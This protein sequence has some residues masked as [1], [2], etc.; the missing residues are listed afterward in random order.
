MSTSSPT[1][2][3]DLFNSFETDETAVAWVLGVLELGENTT[4]E[5]LLAETVA[6][7]EGI[8]QELVTR[9]K[10]VSE[11]DKILRSKFMMESNNL[12]EICGLFE[13]H[14]ESFH[15]SGDELGRV[16]ERLAV[17]DNERSR[18][19]LAAEL[20][21]L[22]QQL[23]SGNYK[24]N[25]E[26]SSIEKE[27]RNQL[28]E[29]LKTLPWDTICDRLQELRVILADASSTS[30]QQARINISKVSEDIE[31]KMLVKFE[32]AAS[33]LEQSSSQF[34]T[35]FWENKQLRTLLADARLYVKCLHSFNNGFAVQKKF[36]YSCL[37]RM[38]QLIASETHDMNLV[39]HISK[40]IHIIG[41]VGREQF[42]IIRQ[43]FPQESTGRVC[44]LLLQKVFN[45]SSI[46]LV[47]KINNTLTPSTIVDALSLPESLDMLVVIREK[48]T[49]LQITVKESITDDYVFSS[50]LKVFVPAQ[51]FTSND[52]INP[53]VMLSERDCDDLMNDLVEQALQSHL[54]VFN[55][56][57]IRCVSQEYA[58]V[59]MSAVGDPRL[60]KSDKKFD[61]KSGINMFTPTT[62]ETAAP[63]WM[64][65]GGEQ[66]PEVNPEKFID[67]AHVD[68]VMGADN[69]VPMVL[70]ITSD[71]LRRLYG[72]GRAD[73]GLKERVKEIYQC[74]LSFQIDFHLLP[75]LQCIEVQFDQ[76]DKS[77]NGINIGLTR[78]ESKVRHS[79]T[80]ER[81][82][83]KSLEAI[84]A[85]ANWCK[86]WMRYERNFEVTYVRKVLSQ[87]NDIRFCKEIHRKG[88][89]MAKARLLVVIQMLTTSI[90]DGIASSLKALQS[91]NDYC[92]QG[93]K[94]KMDNHKP[95]LACT[96][97][98]K[99][100][101]QVTDAMKDYEPVLKEVS[102]EACDIFW[103]SLAAKFS[104]TFVKHLH[105]LSVNDVGVGTLDLDLMNYQSNLN[106]CGLLESA[107]M[108][109]DLVVI[110]AVFRV[111]ISELSIEI[112][113]LSRLYDANVVSSLA[114]RRADSVQSER[115]ISIATQ[116]FV[117]AVSPSPTWRTW[118]SDSVNEFSLRRKSKISH[119]IARAPKKT[120]K[121]PP[122]DAKIKGSSAVPNTKQTSI[123]SSRDSDAAKNTVEYSQAAAN[124]KKRTSSTRSM[125]SFFG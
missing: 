21:L 115:S 3:M 28:P 12:E 47:E 63:P 103:N 85:L 26:V 81:L 113:D 54:A 39:D 80:R 72:I 124:G 58:S 65:R 111:P 94:Y 40:M 4:H 49:A 24:S 78:N 17:L 30:V 10:N 19:E 43:I 59:L 90:A 114:N 34:V 25:D 100:I 76:Q 82:V 48:L 5:R 70:D 41:S 9:K 8:Q 38:Q 105:T 112:E 27:S 122:L 1:V 33:V 87:D 98:C 13:H 52:A 18:L 75:W 118:N 45:D 7:E 84:E 83:H 55:Q 97:I 61:F 108:M 93:T 71:A 37:M 106:E 95:S 56:K 88:F 91:Q 50:N 22:V 117:G 11:A 79:S 23:E 66:V 44:R 125:F 60:F 119:L 2:S 109:A 51:K 110:A 62:M 86:A 42:Q 16:G 29:G 89:D 6:L 53:V 31:M 46:N 101:A 67:L 123:E 15:R 57:I 96:S 107:E 120:I 99:D 73:K 102:V 77:I 32:M 104:S 69:L 36:L 92:P 14:L 64:T 68:N 74:E 35:P 116:N 20:L 121:D